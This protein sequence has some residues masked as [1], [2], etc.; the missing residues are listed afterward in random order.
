MFARCLAC[1]AHT[2][3]FA[4]IIG[5]WLVLVPSI[6]VLRVGDMGTLLAAFFANPAIV[7]MLIIAFHQVW[8]G[9]AAIA[10]S[11]FGWFL[12]LRGFVLMAVPQWIEH[13]AAASLGMLPLVRIGFA[14]LVVIGLWLTFVGWTSDA[15]VK[16]DPKAP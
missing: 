2:R 8:S 6:I 5:P 7:W 1:G 13:G 10:I 4:R 12:A 15:V 9:P 3:A 11:L 14:V 16:R